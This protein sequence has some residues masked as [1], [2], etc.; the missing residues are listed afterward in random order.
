MRQVI[1]LSHSPVA[2][3]AYRFPKTKTMYARIL[4]DA[5]HNKTYRIRTSSAGLFASRTDEWFW[6]WRRRPPAA[7]RVSNKLP[8]RKVS[9]VDIVSLR[10]HERRR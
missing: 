1:N 6:R 10:K 3:L 4:R 8:I 7:T 9:H 2:M 5:N